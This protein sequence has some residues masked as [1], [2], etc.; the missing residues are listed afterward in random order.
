M[1]ISG[2]DIRP[3]NVLRLEGRLYAVLQTQH[4]KPGKGGAYMMVEMKDVQDGT[5]RNLRFRSSE[6]VERALIEEQDH[7]FLYQ[8]GES[9]IFMDPE[10]YGQVAVT[11]DQISGSPD[12]LQ[13]SMRVK[14]GFH[15]GQPL[16]VTLPAQVA[17]EIAEADPVVKGQTAASSYKPAKLDNGMKTMVPPHIETGTKVWI[18]TEDC[19]YVERVKT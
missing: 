4:V 13:P 18:K 15:E 1:K 6:T 5:K 10:S 17:L 14:I 11:A 3:G 19:S 7:D 16:S 12:F 8:E 2:N 9:Y